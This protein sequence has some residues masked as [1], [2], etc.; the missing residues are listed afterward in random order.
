MDALEKGRRG[1]RNYILVVV[2][3]H[4]LASYLFAVGYALAY[5]SGFS[6]RSP[7]FGPNDRFADLVKTSLSYKSVVAPYLD[8]SRFPK[9]PLIF[10]EYY[11]HN[12]YGGIEVL[13]KGGLTHF[14]I[15]P[16]TTL[17]AIVGGVLCMIL[18]SPSWAIAAFTAGYIV[19]ALASVHFAVPISQRSPAL[20]ASMSYLLVLSYPALFMLTRGNFV[21]GLTT[22]CIMAFVIATLQ[23]RGGDWLAALAIAIAL[24]LRPNAMIFLA[25]VPIAIGLRR[26][27]IPLARIAAITGSVLGISYSID[28]WIYPAYSLRAFREG[29]KTYHQ[30]YVIGSSD[31]AF[32]SSIFGAIKL[33]AKLFAKWF[34]GQ[35]IPEN[36]VQAFSSALGLAILVSTVLV[37]FSRKISGSVATFL[38]ASAYALVTPVFADYHLLV[39]V[40]PIAMVFLEL[41][42]K[43]S[44]RIPR[45]VLIVSMVSMVMLIPKSVSTY[46]LEVVLNPAILVATTIYLVAAEWRGRGAR[47]SRLDAAAN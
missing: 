43:G 12:P 45:S 33:F 18:P 5:E 42:E 44:D 37:L 19:M 40:I 41:Q 7:L 47:G 6:I 20:M 29:Y 3:C 11:L 16:L 21:A 30:F 22:L 39:F 17:I 13:A 23:R 26:S 8:L 32:N 38:M 36:V 27:I 2:A 9:W 15:P 46:P 14:H 1:A 28:R 35:G 10:Q 34:G 24:N 25:T 4:A 31:Y